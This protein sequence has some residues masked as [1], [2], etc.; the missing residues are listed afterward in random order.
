MSVIWSSDDITEICAD[1]VCQ[2]I[3]RWQTIRNIELIT[4]DNNIHR[5]NN[6]EPTNDT[7]KWH[8]TPAS[9]WNN[10]HGCLQPIVCQSASGVPVVCRWGFFW[11]LPFAVF[12]ASRWRIWTVR[13]LL[14][15]TET[16]EWRVSDAWVSRCKLWKQ[17]AWERERERVCVVCV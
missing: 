6:T 9:N 16:R 7:S 13:V 8:K 17:R 5:V 10:T 12:G 15:L 1:V 4:G 3:D 11:C 14:M 2:N